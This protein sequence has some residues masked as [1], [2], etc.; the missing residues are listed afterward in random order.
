MRRAML[1]CTILGAVAFVMGT[2]GVA[3]AGGGC[4]GDA[5]QQDATGQDEVTVAMVD[6]CFSASLTEVDP[7]TDVTFMNEDEGI[8][9]NV[10]GT[11]WGNY[12]DMVKGDS[13]T[14]I[15]DDPGIYPFACSYHPGMTGAI[16]VGG[17][18]GVGNGATVSTAP[19]ELDPVARRTQ[20]AVVN[21]LG[22]PWIAAVGAIG[23]AIGAIVARSLGHR[24]AQPVV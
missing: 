22:A 19:P 17:G 14:A 21:G 15:F 2:Q 5:T 6:A 8:T 4:H 9:H 11:G 18:K 1:L 23:F 12:A 10:G 7:G 13:Y 24:S 3:L 20:P 16:V